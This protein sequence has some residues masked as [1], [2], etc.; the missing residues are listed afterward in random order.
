MSTELT[1]QGRDACREAFAARIR[2]LYG[3]SSNATVE[4]CCE[5]EPVQYGL[6]RRA[7][8]AALASQVK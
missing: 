6:W 8:A 4:E 2:Y 7:W 1:S 5:A 3:W